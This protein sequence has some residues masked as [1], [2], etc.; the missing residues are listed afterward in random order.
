[1]MRKTAQLKGVQELR[2][3]RRLSGF[4]NVGASEISSIELL[5]LLM[6]RA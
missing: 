2:H 4:Q 1:M 5:D 6:G 3:M